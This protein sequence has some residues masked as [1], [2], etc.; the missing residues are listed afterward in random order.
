MSSLYRQKV[1]AWLREQSFQADQVL[2]VGGKAGLA[3]DQTH[4]SSNRYQ[5]MDIEEGEGVNFVHDLNVFTH[6]DDIFGTERNPRFDLIFC[7]HVFEYIHN[8]YNAVANLYSWLSEGGTL[9]INLPFVYPLHEPKGTDY[10]RYTHEWAEKIFRDKFKFSLVES[11]VLEASNGADLLRGAYS[12]EKMH[13]RKN[14][15]SWKEIGTI[16]KAVK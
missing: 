5:V 6:A 10:L 15:D 3:K 1:N 4:V 11:Y 13:M 12:E 9:V 7:L 8:P 14:D 16:I 2:D